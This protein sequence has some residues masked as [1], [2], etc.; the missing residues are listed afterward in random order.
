MIEPRREGANVCC[1]CSFLSTVQFKRNCGLE[2]M[3]DLLLAESIGGGILL[4]VLI[5]FLRNLWGLGGTGWQ[6][7]RPLTSA[8]WIGVIFMG[9]LY[10]VIWYLYSYFKLGH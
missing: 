2:D 3:N 5:Y 9:I 4:S 1:S 8:G 10:G 7:G 6:A